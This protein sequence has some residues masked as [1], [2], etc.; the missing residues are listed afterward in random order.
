MCF[1]LFSRTL[2]VISVF[3]FFLILP[4]TILFICESTGSIKLKYVDISSD[5][6]SVV[7]W[8]LKKPKHT[9]EVGVKLKEIY[10]LFSNYEY[11]RS[12]PNGSGR[13]KNDEWILTSY[14]VRRKKMSPFTID[15]TR[16]LFFTSSSSNFST[17][18]GSS[19][20]SWSWRIGER[21]STHITG[22]RRSGLDLVVYLYL[23]V[24]PTLLSTLFVWLFLFKLVWR[25]LFHIPQCAHT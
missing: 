5:I 3:D 8:A 20:A 23:W 7:D 4:S 19:W 15:D 6:A 10:Q 11:C 22:M 17:V 16:L 1:D 12:L 13:D 9:E 21:N 18:P 2:V 25:L 14:L 24:R